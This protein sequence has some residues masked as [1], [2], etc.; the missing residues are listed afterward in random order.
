MTTAATTLPRRLWTVAGAFALA[1]VALM[2]VGIMLQG[3]PSLTEGQEGIRR[4]YADGDLGL[5]LTGGFI[6]VIG[7]VCMVPALVFL[8]H[9]VGQR[10]E[11][12]RWATQAAAAAGLGYVA[13]VM[14]SGFA[15]GAASLWGVHNGLDLDTALVVNDIRNF[16]YFISLALLGAHAIGLG[17]AAISDRFAV[18][19]V[20]WGGIVTG[21]VLI[22]GVPAASVGL[23]DYA[24]LLW[25]VWWVGLAVTMLRRGPQEAETTTRPPAVRHA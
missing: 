6:E 24:T 14:G 21:A 3:S 7:F 15:P 11:A 5:I 19:W 25:L 8:A 17:I 22:A 1:H 18:R 12:G 10:S 4:S 16:A 9:A 23:Q 2:L 13:V 20:G